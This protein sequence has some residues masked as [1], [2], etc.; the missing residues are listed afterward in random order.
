M[1]Q[2]STVKAHTIARRSPGVLSN[3]T[4]GACPRVTVQLARRAAAREA[5]VEGT[6]VTDM[7]RA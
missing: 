3:G 1:A 6:G 5:D 7:E 4:A 2:A